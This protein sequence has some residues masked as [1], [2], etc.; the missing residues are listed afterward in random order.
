MSSGKKRLASHAHHPSLLTPHRYPDEQ[1]RVQEE[2]DR[3]VGRQRLPALTDQPRLPYVMAFVYEAMRFSSLV[4]FTIPHATRASAS[5]L[6]YHIPKDTVIFINQLSVNHDPAQW[7]RPNHF[8]PSRFLDA[9][10]QLDGDLTSRVLAFSL[11]RRRCPGEQLARLLLF[12]FTA[13]LAHQC[14]FRG[15]PQEG[16]MDL[17]YGLTIKPLA[18]Q[19]HAALRD[20][21]ELLEQAAWGQQSE[22]SA[23]IPDEQAA[24]GRE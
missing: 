18:F 19:L 1:A 21:G 9:N 14:H 10:G 7:Q 15:H 24:Q 5:V 4:P 22:D 6:G 16:G 13:V 17:D 2:V 20:N 23:E 11:G 3:V 8:E 12:L